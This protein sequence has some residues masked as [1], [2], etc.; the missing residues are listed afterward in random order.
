MYCNNFTLS[1]ETGN[2]SFLREAEGN[3]KDVIDLSGPLSADRAASWKSSVRPRLLCPRS[4]LSGAMWWQGSRHVQSGQAT[5]F[6]HQRGLLF[7]KHQERDHGNRLRDLWH[8]NSCLWA[9]WK[10]WDHP[11]S[12]RDMKFS[13]EDI[14]RHPWDIKCG[15]SISTL[16]YLDWHYRHALMHGIKFQ[17]DLGIPAKYCGKMK[18]TYLTLKEWVQEGHEHTPNTWAKP[19]IPYPTPHTTPAHFWSFTKEKGQWAQLW[20]SP[21]LAL[22]PDTVRARDGKKCLPACNCFTVCEKRADSLPVP[23]IQELWLPHVSAAAHRKRKCP[24]LLR[25]TL[26]KKNLITHSEW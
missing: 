19:V 16:T 2:P 20:S 22:C 18:G 1:R 11:S 8:S 12:P 17:R 9:T 15:G 23:S 14:K 4:C 3:V 25:K 10:T 13:I 7:R 6:R 21:H 5:P 24:C 26:T